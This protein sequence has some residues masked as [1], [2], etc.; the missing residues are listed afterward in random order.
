MEPRNSVSI[1]K[2]EHFQIS[3]VTVSVDWLAVHLIIS[4]AWLQIRSCETQRIT[5]FHNISSA[6]NKKG[7]QI[8]IAI[9]DFSKAFDTVQYELS[10]QVLQ[11]VKDAK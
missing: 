10:G 2:Y 4:P 5:T 3:S 11:E 7:S 8:D 1:A 9:L 6:Y